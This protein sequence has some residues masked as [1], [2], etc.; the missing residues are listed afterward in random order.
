MPTET[1]SVMIIVAAASGL[2]ASVV[3]AAVTLFIGWRNYPIRKLEATAEAANDNAAAT[4]VMNQAE[5]QQLS[6]YDQLMQMLRARDEE[7]GKIGHQQVALQA[8]LI[9]LESRLRIVQDQYESE[10]KMREQERRLRQEYYNDL[11][12]EREMRRNTEERL[13]AERSEHAREKREW[14]AVAHRLQAEVD[15]LRAKIE[16]LEIRN[17]NRIPLSV[18]TVPGGTDAHSGD[19]PGGVSGRTDRDLSSSNEPEG[20]SDA[21]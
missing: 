7:I 1:E 20:E 2:I 15:T 8:K 14:E 3:T 12:K 19:S 13:T 11:V 4:L 17:G 21:G 6:N 16:Q 10:K 5:Q 18:T 9:E